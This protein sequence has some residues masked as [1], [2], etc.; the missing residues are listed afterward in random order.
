MDSLRCFIAS[1]FDH[2][3]VDEIFD[4]VIKRVL[5]EQGIIPI[6]VD[7]VNHN[8]KI[9]QK[10]LS[11]IHE[12]QFGITDLTF[13]R[14]SVYFEAG[15]LEGQGKSVIYICR[16]DHLIPKND[17]IQGNLKIHFDLVTKNIIP[18]NDGGHSQFFKKLKSRVNLITK[19][20]KKRRKEITDEIISRKDFEKISSYEKRITILNKIID[21]IKKKDFHPTTY[22][23]IRF[24]KNDASILKIESFISC[25]KKDL[26]DTAYRDDFNHLPF[27]SRY[28]LI[29]SVRSIKSKTISLSL[30]T[31][32][33]D[34]TYQYK[35]STVII[36][37]SISSLYQLDRLMEQIPLLKK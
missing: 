35:N 33:N 15:F 29:I 37:D 34:F 18:W 30:H 22:N 2:T 32:V 16:R 26:I 8:E 10:I 14:P 17:D 12:C 19:P 7:R 36:I 23:G 20:I 31:P 28:I 27:I 5:K 25:S 24:W 13:A 11:L 3:D 9:D 21:R 6:R 1:A 4:K